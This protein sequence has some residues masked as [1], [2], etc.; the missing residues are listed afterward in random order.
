MYITFF[1]TN[2]Y[3]NDP[4]VYTFAPHNSY[5]FNYREEMILKRYLRRL[6][7]YINLRLKIGKWHFDAWRRHILYR[8]HIPY[9]ILMKGSWVDQYEANLEAGARSYEVYSLIICELL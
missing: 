4:S 6:L 2:T 9:Q 8:V 7:N 1:I 5:E 3:K